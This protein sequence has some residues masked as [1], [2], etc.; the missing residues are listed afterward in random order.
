[1]DHEGTITAKFFESSLMLRPSAAQLLRAALGEEIRLPPV[2]APPG[3][4]AFDVTLDG[5]VLRAGVL[6]D[7]IV[8]FAVPDGQNLY[9]DPVPDGMVPTSVEI[10]PDAG[11]VVKPAVFPPTIPHTLAGTGETLQIFEGDVVIRVPLTHMSR[12]LTRLDD[13]SLVQRVEGTVRW[14]S[15]DDDVC[16]LPRI[17][18][19]TVDLPAARHDSP[20]R[21]LADPNGMDISAHL[22]KMV[23]RRTDKSLAEV[24]RSMAGDDDPGEPAQQL[25]R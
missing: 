24:L 1:M 14:Q 21:E 23:D 19:F 18:R 13:G 20:G 17:E 6:H 4:V 12:S 10:E 16:H 15:C 7:L 9:G 22:T 2:E 3:Q 25:D 5:E 11:L 8:R